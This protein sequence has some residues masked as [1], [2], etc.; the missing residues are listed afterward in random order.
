ML[1]P[2]KYM[3]LDL[4]YIGQARTI[5]ECRGSE[6]TVAQ[7]WSIVKPRIPNATL[8]AF[9]ISLSLLYALETVSLENGILVWARP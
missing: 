3:G 5:L 7:L 9:F 8:S 4:S 6:Q 1:M 2:N